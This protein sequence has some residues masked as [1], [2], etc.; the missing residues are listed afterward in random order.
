MKVEKS[1]QKEQTFIYTARE[2]DNN[3]GLYYYRARYMDVT[4]GRFTTM[5]PALGDAN[6]PFSF[7]G[8]NYVANN[9]VNLRDPFGRQ[10]CPEQYWECMSE[11]A[12]KLEDCIDDCI[13]A[14]S[15]VGGAMII[16][17]AVSGVIG[18]GVGAL[19]GA[20]ITIPS[21][22]TLN[23]AID[24][25]VKGCEIFYEEDISECESLWW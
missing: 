14:Y 15:F 1:E 9:P 18:G 12:F 8:Y 20:T 2:W 25:C 16:G 17:E 19:L 11:A 5:D 3:S 22:Q 24:L 4:V 6:D 23:V 7:H 10:Q 13:A 21:I